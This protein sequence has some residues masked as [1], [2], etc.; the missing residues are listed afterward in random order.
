MR[1][2]K[3]AAKECR[4]LVPVAQL[5]CSEHW[6]I[7]PQKLQMAIDTARAEGGRGIHDLHSLIRRAVRIVGESIT[8]EA[9][10]TT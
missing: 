4:E 8:R 10:C 5:M 3:C 6:T 7:L 9:P 1:E 2:H